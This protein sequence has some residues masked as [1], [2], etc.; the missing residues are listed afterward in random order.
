LLATELSLLGEFE[1]RERPP[2][3]KPRKIVAEE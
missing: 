3:Q 1:V 2:S